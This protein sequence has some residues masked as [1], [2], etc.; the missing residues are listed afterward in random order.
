MK[1]L[2]VLYLF[3]VGVVRRG[4]TG[5]GAVDLER[6]LGK[7]K[8]TVE[9]RQVLADVG[10]VPGQRQRSGGEQLRDEDRLACT[11]DTPVQ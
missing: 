10:G 6:G 3:V 4:G 7:V 8:P 1:D 2:H 11:V 9:A 5:N